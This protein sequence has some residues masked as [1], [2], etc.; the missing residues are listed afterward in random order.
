MTEIQ[1]RWSQP[2]CVCANS[3]SGHVCLQYLESISLI[4]VSPFPGVP[5][6]R[7]FGF[8]NSRI[9]VT[10]SLLLYC[11]SDVNDESNNKHWTLASY[12]MRAMEMPLSTVHTMMFFFIPSIVYETVHLVRGPPTGYTVPASNDNIGVWDS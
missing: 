11:I 1:T 8:Q 4:P 5:P 6:E 9:G 7:L 12:W 2:H 3:F 10:P